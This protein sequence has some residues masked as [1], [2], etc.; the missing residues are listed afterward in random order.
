[1]LNVVSVV[2]SGTYI[3]SDDRGDIHGSTG[4]GVFYRDP[5][6]LSR[7]VLKIEGVKLVHGNRGRDPVLLE[8]ISAVELCGVPLFGKRHDLRV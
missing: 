1:L 8:D 5:R 7:F 2:S 4:Q 3:V 6:H